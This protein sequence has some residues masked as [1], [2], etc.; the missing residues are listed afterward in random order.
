MGVE[1][2]LIL[3]TV[4]AHVLGVAQYQTNVPTTPRQNLVFLAN[5]AFVR[6]HHTAFGLPRQQ[7]LHTHQLIPFR[8]QH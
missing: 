6:N 1:Q 2:F 7:I 4:A 3:S 5:V 8:G